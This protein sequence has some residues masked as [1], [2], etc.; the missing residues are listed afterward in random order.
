MWMAKAKAIIVRA[1]AIVAKIE[2]FDGAKTFL[3]LEMREE[4]N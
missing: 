3:G 1:K 2:V 4:F